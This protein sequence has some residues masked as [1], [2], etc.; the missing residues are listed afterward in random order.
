MYDASVGWLRLTRM[1]DEDASNGPR[2]NR[3]AQDVSDD[4]NERSRVS[5]WRGGVASARAQ[6]QDRA[7][8]DKQESLRHATPLSRCAFRCRDSAYWNASGRGIMTAA[9]RPALCCG[10]ARERAEQQS[11]MRALQRVRQ[12]P[13]ISD[14]A[15]SAPPT[16]S[17]RA[18]GRGSDERDV[19]RRVEQH[20]LTTRAARPG[21]QGEPVSAAAGLFGQSRIRLS[22]KLLDTIQ[23]SSRIDA[24][25]ELTS[26]VGERVDQF[27]LRRAATGVEQ[28]AIPMARAATRLPVTGAHP[29]RLG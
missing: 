27:A 10:A 17:G 26:Q 3:L 14:L 9:W 12:L 4:R 25:P 6:G 24:E 15:P 29:T 1:Q 22:S 20:F 8:A 18:Y 13:C 16:S 21:R 19:K 7:C 23:W 28:H 2:R 5:F 11:G